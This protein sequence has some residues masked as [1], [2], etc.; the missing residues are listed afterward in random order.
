MTL[1]QLLAASL[2]VQRQYALVFDASLAGALAAKWSEHGSTNCVPSPVLLDDGRYML[3]ADV[4]SEVGPG[5]LLHAMLQAS[6]HAAIAAGTTVMEWQD[7]VAM[8]PVSEGIE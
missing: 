1:P 2:A 7:A 4:L 3:S 6:D 8:I 5:G